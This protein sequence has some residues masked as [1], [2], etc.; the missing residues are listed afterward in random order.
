MRL[1]IGNFFTIYDTTRTDLR[2]RSATALSNSLEHIRIAFMGRG[3]HIL[4][5]WLMA[6]PTYMY[7]FPNT[8]FLL[9][10]HLSFETIPAAGKHMVIVDIHIIKVN[11]HTECAW[12]WWLWE[13]K[14]KE[15]PLTNV[16]VYKA[17]VYNTTICPGC[18]D[19][20]TSINQYETTP[21]SSPFSL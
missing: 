3:Q 15:K 9:H 1:Y 10:P 12:R 2:V 8:N 4:W 19:M 16:Q 5:S 13:Q 18:V 17:K 6:A 21:S 14:L 20:T 7:H 11:M